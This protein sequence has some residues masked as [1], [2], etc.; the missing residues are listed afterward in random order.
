M[1]DMMTGVRSWNPSLSPGYRKA[2]DIH[3]G[4]FGKLNGN[5]GYVD[6]LVTHHWHGKLVNRQYL[7]RWKILF[8]HQFDPFTDLHRDE[9]GL[10][11][12]TDAKP[13]LRDDIRRYFEARQEDSIDL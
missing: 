9:N 6:G 3:A 2:L 1:A 4:R 11:Q 5:F 8:A 7:D 12:L 13:G 10:W